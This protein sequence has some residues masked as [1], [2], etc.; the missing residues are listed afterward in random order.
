MKSETLKFCKEK[1]LSLKAEYLA[2]LRRPMSGTK[3]S[4]DRIDVARNESQIHSSAFFRS[5]MAEK[6]KAIEHA[7]ISIEE[8]TY[9]LCVVTGEA[10]SENRL[11]AVPWT[12]VS[13]DA[14]ED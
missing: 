1:L 3:K 9:G 6:L 13:I 4:I 10:I 12:R 11:R 7:L 8:G 5:K 14:T 2:I